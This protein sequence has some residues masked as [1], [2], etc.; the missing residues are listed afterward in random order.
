MVNLGSVQ[1]PMR[2]VWLF[3]WMVP[4][5]RVR[6]MDPGKVGRLG[7]CLVDGLMDT[8]WGDLNGRGLHMRDSSGTKV[9]R[10]GLNGCSPGR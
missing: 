6:T 5:F 8:T 3:T 7:K 1:K 9:L 2:R 10:A 4:S